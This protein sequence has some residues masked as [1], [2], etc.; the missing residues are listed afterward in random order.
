MDTAYLGID[1]GGTGAKTGVFDRNGN[2]LGAAHRTYGPDTTPDG[3]VE[4]PITV[5]EQAARE[6]VREAVAAAGAPIGALA[7]VSQGQ[8]FVSL[9]AGGGPLHPAIL[10]YD[11]R[12]AEEADT[13]NRQLAS[14]PEPHPRVGAIASAPKIVW[15]RKHHPDLMARARRHLL[16]P[17]FLTFRLTGRAVTDP[18]TAGSTGLTRG[19]GV[20][21]APALRAAGILPES[22]G[23]IRSSGS[24]AG[25]VTPEAAR[26]WGLSPETQVVVGT[27]DQYAGAMG[28]GLCRP[29]LLSVATGTC[30]ALVTLTRDA[31]SALPPG[32]FSGPFPIPGFRFVLAYSKTAGVALEW[33]QR[34]LAPAMSMRDLDA[35]AAAVPIGSRGVTACPHFDGRVSP[36][37]DAVV[38]GAFAGLSLHHTRADL[39]R[40]LLE[41]LAFSLREN[42]EA[43]RCQGYETEQIRAIGGA[44]KS[45]FW[46]QMQADVTG[47]PVQRPHVT[48]AATVGAAMLAA[49]GTG[50]FASLA[51]SVES[52][53]KAGRTFLPDA[54]RRERYEEPFRRALA[55]V[56]KN[57][58]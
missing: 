45:D 50:A 11:S 38:R 16:L 4:I 15:L 30:L 23:E 1:I 29:G 21:F 34:V 58:I 44:A 28:A 47:L 42:V 2:L 19:D 37:P 41:S 18:Q 51:S 36:A 57:R 49:T 46:L 22:L 9:D 43:L 13:M 25:T 32:L 12:A 56:E 10:W 33:F 48:E 14:R 20:Y 24:P 52:L 40:A 39:Y 7:V 6:A 55:L 31:P 17:D 27:N 54:A 8:T 53:Y 35:E 3:R 26:E 5:I